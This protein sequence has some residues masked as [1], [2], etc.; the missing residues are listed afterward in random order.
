MGNRT[1][2]AKR[3][4]AAL[5]LVLAGYAGGV[6][7]TNVRPAH[8]VIG[9]LATVDVS[10]SMS[11]LHHDQFRAPSVVSAG[12][13]EVD[14]GLNNNRLLS[15]LPLAPG[16][17]LTPN[18]DTEHILAA[19]GSTPS[20]DD[21]LPTRA[22]L[23]RAALGAVTGLAVT[24]VL[25][26]LLVEAVLLGLVAALRGRRPG[27]AALV[28]APLAGLLA[29]VGVAGQVV[30][31]YR[32]QN[33]RTVD[34]SHNAL[35]ASALADKSL[36]SQ[37]GKR[38]TQIGPYIVSVIALS[39]GL[40]SELVDP[41]A[42]AQ[43]SA[44]NFLLVSDIHDENLLPALEPT[45]RESHIQ[46]VI[47]SG[48]LVQFGYGDETKLSGLAKSIAALKIPFL[49]VKG[50]HDASRAGD[51]RLVDALVKQA[52]NVIP[53]Q[54]VQ[55]QYTVVKVAG[56]SI[57][58]FNDPRYFGDSNDAS[59][60][61][62]EEKRAAQRYLAASGKQLPD[63]VVTHEPVAAEQIDTK[64]LLIDGHL[65][66]PGLDGNRITVGSL[67]AGGIFQPRSAK[68]PPYAFD[69]LSF[70]STCQPSLL[71][72]YTFKDL[73]TSHPERT[74]TTLVNGSAL[75]YSEPEGRCGA[76]EPLSM[77]TVGAA[78]GS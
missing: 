60:T 33:F 28:A 62:P 47:F 10:M 18:V 23:R 30:L 40:R 25:G 49:F 58:G 29:A 43:T 19:T 54:P 22:Q 13:V 55:N 34:A 39:N 75:N 41:Q 63:I 59:I 32:P 73:N 21:L 8:A 48:D 52:P 1:A 61:D 15:W 68:P 71:A 74:G 42:Q 6:A 26:A 4:L 67:T 56:V 53:L 20:A 3:V 51:L 66:E 17:T 36:I 24:F 38:A 65:H 76:D 14:F 16:M 12:P 11:P 2:L 27:R 45:I 72:R 77:S 5:G 70:S 44:V 46:A 7:G 31:V 57:G 64:G 9:D 37:I 78:G 69:I 35:V 50:N